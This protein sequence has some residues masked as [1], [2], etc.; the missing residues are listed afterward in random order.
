[1]AKSRYA[2]ILEQKME[3]YK[4]FTHEINV[5]LK[6][7]GLEWEAVLPPH[8]SDGCTLMVKGCP[9]IS[10]SM[11]FPFVAFNRHTELEEPMWKVASDL[12]GHFLRDERNTEI[13]FRDMGVIS[14][15]MVVPTLVNAKRNQKLLEEIPHEL[16]GDG[17]LAIVLR[18]I[19]HSTDSLLEDLHLNLKVT[20]D[21][22]NE[23][24]MD[25][26]TLYQWSLQNPENQRA[27]RIEPF[28]TEPDKRNILIMTTDGFYW[29]AS[30]M[31]YKDKIRELTD[32]LGGNLILFPTSINQCVV[33]SK[34]NREGKKW[35]QETLY[36]AKQNGYQQREKD[37]SDFIYVYSRKTDEVRKTSQ[38][39]RQ[40]PQM[41]KK[42]GR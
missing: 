9:Q 25:F 33:L 8:I 13:A 14:P 22:L 16:Y 15:N 11:I 27:I 20:A 29:G 19:Y 35:I 38:R 41:N 2:V 3:F 40:K 6:K 21:L 39:V 28:G 26:H 34:E 42:Q 31:L 10:D 4:S 32:K 18:I 7:L 17:D 30:A 24:D 1:M 12:I 5:I 23:F 36:N 37:L